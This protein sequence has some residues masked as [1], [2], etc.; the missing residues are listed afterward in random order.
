MIEISLKDSEGYLLLPLQRL[1]SGLTEME[2]V[3]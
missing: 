3:S 1:L 2:H